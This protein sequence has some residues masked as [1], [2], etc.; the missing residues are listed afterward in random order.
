MNIF[1]KRWK[2]DQ[3][4][5]LIDQCKW[6]SRWV[7]FLPLW[8]EWRKYW[9]KN[10]FASPCSPPCVKLAVPNGG[11]PPTFGTISLVRLT[12]SPFNV[13]WLL[14][15]VQWVLD[16]MLDPILPHGVQTGFTPLSSVTPPQWTQ[17]V[18][19]Y[20]TSNKCSHIPPLMRRSSLRFCMRDGPVCGTVSKLWSQD[21]DGSTSWFRWFRCEHFSSF[22]EKIKCDWF[23]LC[24]NI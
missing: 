18:H 10:S 24:R 2:S 21:D 12:L 15:V 9:N 14:C 13:V 16:P 4:A 3:T 8:H 11:L 1:K 7:Q 19:K 17:Q 20:I 6:S 5:R 23:Y 22:R